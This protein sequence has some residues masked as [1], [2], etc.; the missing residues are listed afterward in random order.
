MATQN[1]EMIGAL[2]YV[3]ETMGNMNING[4]DSDKHSNG[5]KAINNCILDYTARS[6]EEQAKKLIAEQMM[7]GAN[8]A[9]PEN[10]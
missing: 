10:E 9:A 7:K 6:K 3:L 5:L 1:E 2:K 4:W 8:G